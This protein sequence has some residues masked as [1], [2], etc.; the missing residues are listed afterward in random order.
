MADI[1]MFQCKTGWSQV[2]D[3][4]V[5]D[6][7][8]DLTGYTE[9]FATYGSEYSGEL[10]VVV[11]RGTGLT[12]QFLC[13]VDYGSACIP[14]LLPTLGDVIAFLKE[15]VPLTTTEVAGV[16]SAT[17]WWAGDL[18]VVVFS[19]DKHGEV[20]ALVST[21]DDKFGYRRVPSYQKLTYNP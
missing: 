3:T 17:G 11:L 10:K 15:V 12:P 4:L 7:N 2:P 13:W 18:P 8:G 21:G 5:Y 6:E 19:V 1:D 16:A 14:V 20:Q 9:D